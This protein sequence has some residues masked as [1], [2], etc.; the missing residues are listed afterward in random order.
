MGDGRPRITRHRNLPRRQGLAAR[1]LE[2][3]HEL[4]RLAGSR[5]RPVDAGREQV[6][7]GA[8]HRP[9]GQRRLPHED[10]SRA[11]SEREADPQRLVRYRRRAR[12]GEAKRIPGAACGECLG[13]ALRLPIRVCPRGDADARPVRLGL[14]RDPR[15]G[16][17]LSLGDIRQHRR[18]ALNAHARGAHAEVG[19]APGEPVPVVACEVTDGTRLLCLGPFVNRQALDAEL[20][21]RLIARRVDTQPRDLA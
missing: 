11:V 1:V 4:R 17:R 6:E 21:A 10:A 5:E 12:V 14:Q 13:E 2:L 15:L 16:G 9:V 3:H 18:R 7:L 19:A 8:A 20:Q